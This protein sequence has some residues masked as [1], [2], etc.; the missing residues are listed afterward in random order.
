MKNVYKYTLKALKRLYEYFCG[1]ISSNLK[2][3]PNVKRTIEYLSKYTFIFKDEKV[4]SYQCY[5]R[6]KKQNLSP[7]QKG[8]IQMS[9]RNN[10]QKY[11]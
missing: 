9:S 1:K 11:F 4:N 7:V 10:C 5:K 6:S 8:F 3:N 2:E